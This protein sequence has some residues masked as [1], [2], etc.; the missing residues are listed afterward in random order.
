MKGV[1]EMT[2]SDDAN[3]PGE[4]ATGHLPRPGD[5]GTAGMAGAAGAG[6]A[7][8]R[9]TDERDLLA[10]DLNDTFVRQMFAI[11][12]DL[13]A[14]LSHLEHGTGGPHAAEKI[15][16]AIAGLDQAI[17]GLRNAIVGGQFDTYRRR[18]R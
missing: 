7:G 16:R 2:T 11:S 1:I 14:A 5:G 15:R 12:L 6:E 9:L 3:R 17:D 10:H 13:H 4:S 8:Y 18:D